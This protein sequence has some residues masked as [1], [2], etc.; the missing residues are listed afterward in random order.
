MH[1]AVDVNA[2]PIELVFELVEGVSVERKDIDAVVGMNLR[3]ESRDMV[4]PDAGALEGMQIT[5]IVP[6]TIRQT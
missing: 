4:V 1:H 6:L 5:G 2:V 3:D